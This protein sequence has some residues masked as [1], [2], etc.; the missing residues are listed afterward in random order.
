VRR[1]DDVYGWEQTRSQG[2]VIDVEHA[3]VGRM[4]LPGPAV[5]FD[6]QPFAGGRAAHLPPPLLGEHN[7]EVAHWLADREAAG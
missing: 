1:L 3:T 4:Q 6:D 7:T 5:R 2:L